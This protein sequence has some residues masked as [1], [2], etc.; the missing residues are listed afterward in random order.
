MLARSFSSLLL[1]FLHA[2][3]NCSTSGG[4]KDGPNKTTVVSMEYTFFLYSF[5]IST[6]L[7]RTGL[8]KGV[9]FTLLRLFFDLP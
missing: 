1:K 5:R 7:K 4:A 2:N 9:L 6:I 3:A 8:G